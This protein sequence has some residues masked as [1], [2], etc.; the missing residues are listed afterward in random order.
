MRQLT[1]SELDFVLG[2]GGNG[3]A[4]WS[5]R[6]SDWT[7]GFGVPKAAHVSRMNCFSHCCSSKSFDA[8]HYTL[9]TDI[10]GHLSPTVYDD[11]TPC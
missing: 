8:Y 6:N 4:C 3:C 9:W 2:A 11:K 5:S 10:Q 7:F 1:L